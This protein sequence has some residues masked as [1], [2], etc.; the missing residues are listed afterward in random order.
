MV[1][2]QMEGHGV[3]LKI[4][5]LGSFVG[6]FGDGRNQVN[7]LARFTRSR[8]YTVFTRKL[9]AGVFPGGRSAATRKKSVDNLVTSY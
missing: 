7:A 2:A 1:A 3:K 9:L 5:Q 8:L 4:Q 6:I